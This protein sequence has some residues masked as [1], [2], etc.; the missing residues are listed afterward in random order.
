MHYLNCAIPYTVSRLQYGRAYSRAPGRDARNWI[1]R[2]AEWSCRQAGRIG[3]GGDAHLDMGEQAAQNAE[4]RRA[5][6]SKDVEHAEIAQELQELQASLQV[7][8]VSVRPCPSPDFIPKL[9]H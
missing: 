8:L 1:L 5:L 2:S 7:L 6:E 3:D 4:A 9:L